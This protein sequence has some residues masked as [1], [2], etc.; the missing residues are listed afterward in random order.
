MV[1]MGSLEIAIGCV[2]TS[3]SNI[4]DSCQE[5]ISGKSIIVFTDFVFLFFELYDAWLGPGIRMLDNVLMF[6]KLVEALLL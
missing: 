4:V 6:M 1:W 5:R 2:K 3:R